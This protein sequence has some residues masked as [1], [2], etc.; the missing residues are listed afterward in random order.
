MTDN[1]INIAGIEVPSDS[2]VFLA[3]LGV[4]VLVALVC[5]VTGI[6]A[7]LSKKGS[8]RH[9]TLGTIYYW[10]LS[11]VYLSATALSVMRWAADYHLFILGTLSFATAT[12]GPCGCPKTLA[13]MGN[14]AHH[15][16][17]QLLHPAIDSFLRRQREESTALERASTYRFLAP[18]WHDW[19]IA[20]CPRTET[21]CDVMAFAA[22]KVS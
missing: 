17:G 14:F 3:I 22:G 2:P 12:L 18:A 5:V 7:M 4:H 1:P 9:P 19:N 16:H 20:H 21:L 15:R 8:A 11:V 6:V 10:A 13:Q